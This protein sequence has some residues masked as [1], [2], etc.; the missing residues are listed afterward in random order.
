[1]GDTLTHLQTQQQVEDLFVQV[2]RILAPGGLFAITFR[3]YTAAACG[4]SRFIAVRS[5]DSR[6]HTCFLEAQESHMIVHDIVHERSDMAWRMNVS[7]YRKLRLGAQW[8][9]AAL[10]R[11]GL[12]PAVSAGPRGM[13]QITARSSGISG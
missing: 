5:D 6:I 8:T 2:A 10:H 7:S 3:D 13:M 4:D 12:T 1:M 9:T 11:A